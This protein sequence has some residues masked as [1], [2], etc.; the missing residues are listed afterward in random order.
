MVKDGEADKL[1]FGDNYIHTPRDGL[2]IRNPMDKDGI[3]QDWDSATKLWEY[4]I[5]SRLTSF[6]PVN[7][8]KG[9][10]KAV[11]EDTVMEG[12]D[13]VEDGDGGLEEHPLLM[14]ETAWNTPKNREKS[15]EVA[16]ESWNCPAFWLARNSVLAAY[17]AG[18]STALVIDVGA[19]TIT[20]TPIH[21][22]LILKKGIQRS[23]LGGNWLG[24]QVK[25]M[26][27]TQEPPVDIVPHYMIKSKTAVNHGEPANATY[28]KFDFTPS[29][30]YHSL[31]QDRVITEF[32][33]SVVHVWPG[34]GRLYSGQNEDYVKTHPG[35]PFEM[36]NGY[37]Q[38]WKIERFKVA[39]GMYD[40][41]AAYVTS[42]SPSAPSK[43]ETIPEM[44]KA[45]MGGVDIDIRMHLLGNVVVTG[46]GSL[47]SGFNDRLYNELSSMFPGAKV[48]ITAAG[49]SAERKFGAWIGGSILASLGTF[50]QM[51]ISRKEYE[52][53]GAGVVEKRCK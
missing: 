52:E 14:S 18:K 41:K 15:I 12:M 8:G 30:S 28:R 45:C 50:H 38:I 11:D 16:M 47:L 51:W 13:S 39:E 20:V 25:H 43:S 37:N 40:E 22:G 23:G 53:F 9:K 46:G 31:Q 19:T 48:K 10:G 27:S 49:L 34:Q 44:I 17:A 42:G 2:E 4:A 5:N 33:E 32:K 24:D 29:P 6:K 35:R 7:N 3:V 1:L 36:P 21:D 26:L